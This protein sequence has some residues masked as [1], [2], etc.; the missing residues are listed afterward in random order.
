MKTI[1]ALDSVVCTWFCTKFALSKFLVNQNFSYSVWLFSLILNCDHW[2]I[3][4]Y[5]LRLFWINE[6]SANSP[7][8]WVGFME[9]EESRRSKRF[10]SRKLKREQKK[11]GRGEGGE[12]GNLFLPPLP[13]HSLFLLSSPLSRRAL[14]QPLATQARREV[15]TV[16]YS[17]FWTISKDNF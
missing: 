12:R 14:S 2:S 10:R 7:I 9:V 6:T 4:P 3:V 15:R 13:F 11:E 17:Q 8:C 16:M 5:T 1:F